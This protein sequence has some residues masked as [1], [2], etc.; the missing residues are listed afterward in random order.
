MVEAAQNKLP[1]EAQ[2]RELQLTKR[3]SWAYS[4]IVDQPQVGEESTD[5]IPGDLLRYKL[6][7][8]PL[9]DIQVGF[10]PDQVL[11]GAEVARCSLHGL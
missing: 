2:S 9:R 5:L 4:I 3:V 6:Q 1:V 7:I 11:V 10:M 8:L